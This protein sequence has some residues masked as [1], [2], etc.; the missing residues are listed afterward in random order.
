MLISGDP[1]ASVAMVPSVT[2]IACAGAVFAFFLY[3]PLFRATSAPSTALRQ[4]L[5]TFWSGHDP[6]WQR[7]RGL[8]RGCQGGLLQVRHRSRASP[9]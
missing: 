1:E 4:R 5:I 7:R 9:A 6:F 8:S 3:R 2:E